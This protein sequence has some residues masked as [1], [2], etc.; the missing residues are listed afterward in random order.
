MNPFRSQTLRFGQ[1]PEPVTPY[2]RAG[3]AWD[4]YVGSTRAHMRAWRLIAFCLAGI[5]AIMAADD[6]HQR[7]GANFVPFLVEVDPTGALIAIEKSM[8]AHKLSDVQFAYQ[9]G[10]FIKNFRS[11]PIDPVVL[12][13]NWLDAYAFAG[14]QARQTLTD[15][16]NRNDPFTD[17]GHKAISVEI[18]SV[19][20]LSDTSFQARWLE[21]TYTDGSLSATDRY[22]GVLTLAEH[23]P[24]NESDLRANPF[25]FTVDAISFTKEN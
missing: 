1:S 9:L 6:L 4:D 25:G 22:I 23:P 21:R 16:A 12:K 15:Q 5:T 10:R 3:Q 14:G 17:V 11:K 24:K 2:Q 18:T 7:L 8:N 19:V 20:R 13:Q